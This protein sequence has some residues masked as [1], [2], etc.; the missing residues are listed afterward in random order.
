[1]H[2]SLRLSRFRERALSTAAA[3][4][5]SKLDVLIRERAGQAAICKDTGLTYAQKYDCSLLDGATVLDDATGFG[6]RVPRCDLTKAAAFTTD[7]VEALKRVIQDVRGILTFPNQRDLHPRDHVA[8]AA[9]FGTPEK[10]LVANGLKAHPEILEIVREKDAAI[11]FGE[12][13]HSDHSFQPLPASYSFLRATSEVTPYGTNNTEFAHCEEAWSA[14]SQS[15]KEVLLP[16]D[17]YHSAGKAY[18]DGRKYGKT[19]PNSREAMLETS[20]MTLIQDREED[21]IPDVVH[22]VVTKHPESGRDAVF[23]SETFTN[24]IL[25]M[26][27]REGLEMTQLIQRHVIQSQFRVQVAYEPHQLAMWD[28]RCLIHRGLQD[29][30]SARR[31]IQRASVSMA[32]PPAAARDF[33]KTI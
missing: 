12:E 29:D 32:R 7:D 2:R 8:F 15:M 22:P 9:H 11:V 21:I 26:T 17:A 30:T 19:T 24:G 14:F 28:N 10:H 6:L 23:I 16:M 25:G 5:A 27:L 18:G 20:S 4:H 1:M 31:V 13:W 3:T 33:H